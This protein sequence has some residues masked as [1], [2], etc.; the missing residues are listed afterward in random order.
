MQNISFEDD[1]GLT[2]TFENV[3]NSPKS[4]STKVN[5]GIASGYSIIQ[6]FALIFIACSPSDLLKMMLVSTTFSRCRQR[7]NKYV[8]QA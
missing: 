2:L 7:G 4:T 8:D 6:E 3:E 5:G 1:W